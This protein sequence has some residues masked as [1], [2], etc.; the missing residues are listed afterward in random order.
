MSRPLPNPSPKT[1]NA[2]ASLTDS[3]LKV[4]SRCMDTCCMQSTPSPCA[5]RE[6]QVRIYGR[7]IDFPAVLKA[8]LEMNTFPPGSGP[9]SAPN[10]R[11]PSE[12]ESLDFPPDPPGG[13]GD[14]DKIQSVL[15]Y[16]WGF[17]SSS[18]TFKN[19]SIPFGTGASMLSTSIDLKPS[20]V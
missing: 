2:N 15:I 4:C 12:N 16:R 9:E 18:T 10:A 17:T 6:G 5:P 14:K 13:R 20:S 3:K 8:K 1:Q 7:K 19:K 11:F